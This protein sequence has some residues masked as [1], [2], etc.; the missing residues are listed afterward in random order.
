[1]RKINI[2]FDSEIFELM[3]YT[4]SILYTDIFTYLPDTSK[5][6]TLPFYIEKKTEVILPVVEKKTFLGDWS[7]ILIILMLTILASVRVTSEKYLYHL[8]QSIFNAQTASRL[9]RERI[10]TVLHPAVRLEI[11]F[12]LS[13]GLFILQIEKYYLRSI[14]VPEILLSLLN[15]TVAFIFINAK[16]FMYVLNGFLFKVQ[17]EVSEYIF[18]SKSGNKIMGL[19]LFPI[20]VLLFFS[21]G[22]WYE[23]LLISGLLTVIF[24]SGNSLFKGIRIIAQK[25]YSIYY[26]ILYL[27][28]LEILPFLIVWRI[29]WRM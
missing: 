15:S 6:D 16:Y 11:L 18:Y 10:I 26:L 17:M 13:T 28:T 3:T 9:F 12:Y 24:F 4:D 21:D 14:T 2:I 1:M 27:C 25:D 22:I 5:I 7:V 29:L 23:I 19:F 8:F 20:A